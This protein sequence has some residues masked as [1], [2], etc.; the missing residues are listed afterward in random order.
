[1]KIQVISRKVGGLLLVSLLCLAGVVFLEDPIIL[2]DSSVE[3]LYNGVSLNHSQIRLY[4]AKFSLGQPLQSAPYVVVRPPKPPPYFVF[5]PNVINVSIGRQ[6]L[7]DRFLVEDDSAEAEWFQAKERGIAYHSLADVTRSYFDGIVYDNVSNKYYMYMHSTLNGTVRVS[8]EN[9]WFW[10]DVEKVMFEGM[11]KR[12]KGKLFR[13]EAE[14]KKWW[15][16]LFCRN[17]MEKGGR[18]D[19]SSI[20]FFSSEDGIRFQKEFSTASAGGRGRTEDSPSIFFNPF[21]KKWVLVLKENFCMWLRSARYVE[22]STEELFDKKSSFGNYLRCRDE[23]LKVPGHYFVMNWNN[24]M[25]WF[26]KCWSRK[27]DDPLFFA[28]TDSLDPKFDNKWLS[29]FSGYTGPVPRL[30]DLY[31]FDA[32]AYERLVCFFF[33]ELCLT[34]FRVA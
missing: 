21:R 3:I 18:T 22:Y 1:M 5:P 12:E 33:F 29:D 27:K 9:G 4:T 28:F 34:F 15:Y 6:I 11:G 25:P 7:V 24:P 13:R 31:T 16:M 19:S 2:D 14:G 26:R 17:K 20:E 10:K 8:S 23:F 30:T 32:F